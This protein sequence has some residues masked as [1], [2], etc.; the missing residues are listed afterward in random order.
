MNYREC[1]ACKKSW[2]N[3][4]IACDHK[5]W[6]Q[7]MK[8]RY[9]KSEDQYRIRLSNKIHFVYNSQGKLHIICKLEEQY[10]PDYIKEEKG[11]EKKIKNTI[12]VGL[13]QATISNLI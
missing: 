11:P 1:I 4:K 5:A 7:I 10:Y 9:F 13:K 6:A 12:I 2:I 3:E 8:E